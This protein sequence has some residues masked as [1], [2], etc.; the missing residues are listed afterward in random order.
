MTQIFSIS[1]QLAGAIILLMWCFKGATEEE[2]IRRYFPGSNIIE[3]DKNNCGTL[4][5]EKLQSVAYVAYIN[6]VAFVNLIIGYMVAFFPSGISN[7][8]L[9]S[10]I[11]TS[12]F[13]VVI[14][15][16][17][18]KIVKK[19][20]EFKYPNDVKVPFDDLKKAGVETIISFDEIDMIADKK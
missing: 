12:I 2:I 8:I 5:K 6:V 4:K 10:I 16:I 13:T 3:R 14:I 1:F 17:E 15:Y 19:F 18:R 7:N 11:A 20:S 9:F